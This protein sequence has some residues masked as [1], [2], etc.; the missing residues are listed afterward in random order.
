MD[1]WLNLQNVAFDVRSRLPNARLELWRNRSS[2]ND[3]R[4]TQPLRQHSHSDI[5][6]T[7]NG[8]SGS[9]RDEHV[10]QAGAAQFVSAQEQTNVV[11][12]TSSRVQVHGLDPVA[13]PLGDPPIDAAHSLVPDAYV[14]AKKKLKV[15]VLE[16]YR[17]V[18]Q[19]LS[20][21]VRCLTYL[22]RLS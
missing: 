7:G 16:H 1:R 11:V 18:V 8:G 5:E 10:R 2:Q 14:H 13:A 9:E 12:A 19:F 20:A 17:C 4:S 6:D 22:I 21:C 15:A 3:M